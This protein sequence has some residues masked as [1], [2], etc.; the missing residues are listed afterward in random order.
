MDNFYE[1]KDKTKTKELLKDSIDKSYKS[2][3]Q[4]NYDINSDYGWLKFKSKKGLL[5][6]FNELNEDDHLV[7]THR[8]YNYKDIEYIEVIMSN[9]MDFIIVTIDI[10]HLEYFIKKYDLVKI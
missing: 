2:E 8:I 10:T 7:F 5:T 9:L 1:L 3:V 6:V 4:T